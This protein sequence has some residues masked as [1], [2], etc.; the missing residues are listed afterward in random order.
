MSSMG[1][2]DKVQ[3]VK[4][5]ELEQILESCVCEF[6]YLW[7]RHMKV[8]KKDAIYN[9]RY[10]ELYSLFYDKGMGDWNGEESEAYVS[11]EDEAF[12]ENCR[13]WKAVDDELVTAKKYAE[14]NRV[15]FLHNQQTGKQ[16]L[17]D[18]MIDKGFTTFQKKMD[19]IKAYRAIVGPEGKPK[20][21]ENEYVG[22]RYQYVLYTP[23][24]CIAKGPQ[25]DKP[26]EPNEEQVSLEKG[27]PL[28]MATLYHF[29]S[30]KNEDKRDSTKAKE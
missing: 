22:E 18:E 20:V 15:Q 12:L 30:G 8:H 5:K 28:A 11:D 2:R 27:E 14:D 19:E 1:K 4:V 13:D 25:K 16:A 24:A 10:K 7:L 6:T 3:N 17:V 9:T 21:Q 26:R 23:K 29:W